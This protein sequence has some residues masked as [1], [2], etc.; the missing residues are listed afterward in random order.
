MMSGK[1]FVEAP[2][3]EYN[4]YDYGFRGYYAPIGRFTSVDPLAEQTPWQSP[5]AYAANNFVNCI[6]YMGLSGM[7]NLSH[8]DGTCHWVAVDADHKIVGMDLGHWDEGVYEVDGFWDGS[9]WDL[10]RYPL[11]GDYSGRS[12]KGWGKGVN[13]AGQFNQSD[14]GYYNRTLGCWVQYRTRPRENA[15]LLVK[16]FQAD[17]SLVGYALM[18]FSENVLSGMVEGGIWDQ[19]L[20]NDRIAQRIISKSTLLGQKLLQKAP[21]II[22]FSLIGYDMYSNNINSNNITDALTLALCSYLTKVMINDGI[23]GLVSVVGTSASLALGAGFLAGC[24]YGLT[25]ILS[26]IQIN[27]DARLGTPQALGTMYGF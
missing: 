24:A 17:K 4:V 8:S 11:I 14:G 3:V 1:E 10:L 16:M 27:I 2:S 12:T 21:T 26:E 18:D 20:K 7:T 22:A 9:Y 13:I 5:Y 19:H 6:D 25:Y 15:D 23:A